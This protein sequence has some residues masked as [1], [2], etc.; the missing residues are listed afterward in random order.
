MRIVSNVAG[1]L[2][3]CGCRDGRL[4]ALRVSV[5]VSWLVL[6]VQLRV[7]I[8]QGSIGR[9]VLQEDA[10]SVVNGQ[11]WRM[12]PLYHTGIVCLFLLLIAVLLKPCVIGEWMR[13][14]WLFCRSKIVHDSAER[15][16]SMRGGVWCAAAAATILL[17]LLVALERIGKPADDG[18]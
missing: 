8:K 16:P 5:V 18:V 11:W 15:G 12:L 3:P 10:S 7:G 9:F 6:L 1:L 14:V 4:C 17:S 2:A 13:L